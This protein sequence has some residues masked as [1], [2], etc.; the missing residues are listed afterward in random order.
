[1]IEAQQGD[2]N[3][4]RELQELRL[5][6][7]RDETLLAERIQIENSLVERVKE[8]NCLYGITR[9]A[10]RHDMP[11]PELAKEIASLI[12]ASWQYPEITCASIVIDEQCYAAPNYQ[13][14]HLRQAHPI[15]VLGEIVGEVDVCYLEARPESD[16]GPFLKEERHLIDAVGDL[17]GRIVEK[18]RVE[19]Q[20]RALSS[21]LIMAQ[22]NE[23]Q[24]IARELH[25]H[26]AQDLAMAK[27]DLERIRCA[28]SADQA[29]QNHIEAVGARI[30]A[31]IASIR[32]LAYG[33]LPIGLT[34]LG[35]VES[36]LSYC[37]EFSQRHGVEVEVFAD[38][39]DKLTLDFETQ[40]NLYRLIQ[41]ALTNTRKHAKAAKASI[42]L[43]GSYPNLLL[44]IE[45]DGCGS[46]MNKCLAKAGR[47]KLMGLWSM[48]ERVR[49][50][51]G[52]I[53]FRSKPGAGMRI[54]V[55]VPCS[56]RRLDAHKKTY[57]DR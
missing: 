11:L 53:T 45:D 1:M 56:R 41:E 18:R 46:D 22:E 25:D 24:R 47:D 37:G 23:R 34:E 26:L 42:R 21:A 13:R 43:I 5:G 9:L 4:L 17:L 31:A 30:S 55:E 32:C 20:M 16:E 14:T 28:H 12:C 15:F 10:Q 33:L 38:G 19:E 36:V 40:I 51:G 8:L 57:A 6:R 7:R 39:I 49:L 3:L 50:L 29:Q 54:T 44:R 35:L 27:L 48:R 2:E 52:K